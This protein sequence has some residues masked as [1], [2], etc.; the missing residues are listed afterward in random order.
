SGLKKV[1]G[2]KL[3]LILFRLSGT[4]LKGVLFGTG[5]TAIIQS[6]SATSVMVVGFVNSGMMKVKQAIGIIMGSLIG[7]S[8][9]GWL[10]SLSAIS[11]SGWV[12][13][14][15]SATITGVVALI[16]ILF[17]KLSK[18]Q[19]KRHV[20]DILMGFAVLMVGMS[21]MSSSVAVLKESSEFTSFLTTFSNPLLGILFGIIMTSILQSASAAIGIL[22]ALSFT[23]A[24]SFAAAF[25]LIMGIGVG[26]AVPVLVSAIGANTGGKR[27]AFAYLFID[28]LGAAIWSIAFYSVN[29]FVH[30]PF[31][32]MVMNPVIIALV[33]TIFRVMTV[34][35]LFP[36]IGIIEKQISRIF[37]MSPEEEAEQAE[38]KDIDRL[39]DRFIPHPTLAINQSM[40]AMGSM[41]RLTRKIV[42]RAIELLYEYSDEGY[43]KVEHNEDS[44]DKYE[45]KLGTYLIKI[46]QNELNHE[47]NKQISKLLHTVSDFERIADHALNIAEAAKELH[48]KE[49]SFTEAAS[50]ELEVMKNAILEITDNTIDAFDASDIAAARDIEPLEECIDELQESIKLNHVKR[51]QTGECSLTQGFILNDI[52]SDYERIADHCSNISLAMIELEADEFDTH[53]YV[54]DLRDKNG[55]E[56]MKSLQKYREKYKL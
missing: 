54:I 8:V 7:T 29:A 31:M 4:P 42:K 10:L 19:A 2:S 14:L 12:E 44:I 34:A 38:L 25:P 21:T 40:I 6:S 45:D 56:F 23:G 27:T 32:D 28:V 53:Q 22:Q 48:E 52:L 24:I 50:K 5:V 43:A 3:E 15:S 37:K 17:V 35:V 20:G 33:N 47:E 39:E 1:A 46:S 18:S 16:G 13:L 55:D 26:A 11:G 30:F 9:T 51:V 36:F 49:L 41:T